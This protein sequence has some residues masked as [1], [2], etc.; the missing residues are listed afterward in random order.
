MKLMGSGETAAEVEFLSADA[1]AGEY[2][3]SYRNADACMRACRAC[4]NFGKTWICPP[5]DYDP[6]DWLRGFGRVTFYGAVIRPVCRDIAVERSLEVML[7]ARMELERQLLEARDCRGGVVL[8]FGGRCS[9]CQQGCTR[10][11]GLPC[12]HPDK[13]APSLESY[14]FD[15]VATASRYLGIDLIWSGDGRI[16]ERLSLVGAHFY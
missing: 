13:A 6:L 15:V 4:P 1:D 16:A 8:A 9:H 11:A 5:F 7:P 3:A 10:P 14:G 2:I 12:R